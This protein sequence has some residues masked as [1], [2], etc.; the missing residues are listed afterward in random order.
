MSRLR[1][2]HKFEPSGTDVYFTQ[3]MLSVQLVDMAIRAR[4]IHLD[5]DAKI[6][7]EGDDGNVTLANV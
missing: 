2:V 6:E 4:S 7:I 3:I 1:A 5:M